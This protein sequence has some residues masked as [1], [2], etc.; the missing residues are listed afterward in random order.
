MFNMIQIRCLTD[1]RG[2][3]H[4]SWSLLSSGQS[5]C[6]ARNPVSKQRISVFRLLVITNRNFKMRVYMN[7]NYDVETAF[8]IFLRYLFMDFMKNEIK[9]ENI[10]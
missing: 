6:E 9:M 4:S 7:L 10:C 3:M 2:Q 1:A 8:A 5:D